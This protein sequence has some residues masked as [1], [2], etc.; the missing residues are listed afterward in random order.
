MKVDKF[1]STIGEYI[2]GSIILFGMLFGGLLLFWTLL[3]QVM[4]AYRS[5][6]ESTLVWI[7]CIFVTGIY[8]YAMLKIL[9]ATAVFFDI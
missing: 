7:I 1:R 5:P 4:P 2:A 9:H 3:S 6:T 8:E